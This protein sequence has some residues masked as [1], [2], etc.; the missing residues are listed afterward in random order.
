MVKIHVD[1]VMKD[2]Y[3]LRIDDE[4][5][6]FFEALWDI[7]EG[8]TYN[9]YLLISEKAVLFDTWKHTYAEEFVD[10]LKSVV[11]P[12]DIDFIVLHH[13]EPDH[14]GSLPKVLKENGY[15]AVVLANPLAKGMISSFYGITPKF[16]PIKDGDTLNI[17]KHTLKFIYAPWLHWPETMMTYIEELKT[18]LTCDVFGGF[19]IPPSLYDDSDEVVAKY[20]DHA[21]KYVV[22]VVGHYKDFIVKG[23]NKLDK[24]GLNIGVIAPSHGLIWRHR[25]GL[26]KEKYLE[27]ALG[28]PAENKVLVVYSSMYGFIEEAVGIFIN[29]LSRFGVK[30]RL[31]R[32]NDVERPSI[33]N[34]LSDAV[35]ASAI[36]LGAATYEN[37]VFPYMDYVVREIVW[38]ASFKKPAIIISSYGWKG[39]AGRKLAKVL[40]DAGYK[41]LDVV[42]FRGSTRYNDRELIK[43]CVKKLVKEFR[44]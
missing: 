43:E 30:V 16:K 10:A 42:E 1:K 11:E 8:I 13:L 34:I 2:L 32:F 37:D 36:I 7:P 15:R 6:R 9:A 20:L 35:D 5:T 18:L 38:K 3:V 22:T 4:N 23:I 40:S 14:S 31:Y 29:E 17:G 41:V 27:W 19:S 26:I 39:A 44:V 28:K 12:R 33:A 25:P 24:Q 21:R